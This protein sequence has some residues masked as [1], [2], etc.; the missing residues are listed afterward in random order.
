MSSISVHVHLLSGASVTLAAEPEE[1]VTSLCQTLR[2][3][4]PHYYVL[5]P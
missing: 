5:G 3:H 2:V 1:S 4:V